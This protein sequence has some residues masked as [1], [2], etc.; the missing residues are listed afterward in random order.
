MD[1]IHMNANDVYVYVCVYVYMYVNIYI[2][3]YINIQII[4]I[5]A[6]MYIIVH[7]YIYNIMS[8]I[9]KHGDIKKTFLC[10]KIS[11]IFRSPL[12]DTISGGQT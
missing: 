5:I 3:I 4:Y 7:I 10:Q 1:T 9:T 8:K 12:G 6:S 11:E 2:Y